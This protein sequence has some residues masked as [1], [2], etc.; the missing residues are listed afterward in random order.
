MWFTYN[1]FTGKLDK[2]WWSSSAASKPTTGLASPEGVIT[3]RYAG[4][5]YI[6]STTWITY[7][8]PITG[9]NTWREV[10]QTTS[11]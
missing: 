10:V 3:S 4:D 7:T 2:V 9:T 8:N 11:A 1:P 6:D 5:M